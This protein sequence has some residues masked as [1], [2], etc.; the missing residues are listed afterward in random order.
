MVMSVDL[1]SGDPVKPGMPKP[2]FKAPFNFR[3]V[4]WGKY[5]VMPDGQHFLVRVPVEHP[6][7]FTML[8]NWPA[9]L[10]K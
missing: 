6:A 10:K 3:F 9:G 1:P 4:L 7:P 8:L 5:A 2:L